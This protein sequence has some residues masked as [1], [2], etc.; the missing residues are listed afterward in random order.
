MRFFLKKIC[1]SLIL[2]ILLIILIYIC[3]IDNLP[4]NVILFEGESLSFNTIL[5]INIETEFSSNPNIERIE[6]KKNVTVSTDANDEG[7]VDYTGKVE[8][9]VK[10]FGTK[11]KEINVDVIENTEVIPMGNLIGIKLYTNGV[12]VVG[13]SE[14]SGS[15]SNKYKPY[16]NSGIEE[17]DVIVEI[18]ENQITTTNELLKEINNSSGDNMNIKYIRNRRNFIYNNERC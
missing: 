16:E 17:G 8:L 13:M 2:S 15:D 5:G 3:N 6:N 18:D 14:I 4:S 9:S 12:L 7:E 10:L 11:V 1:V